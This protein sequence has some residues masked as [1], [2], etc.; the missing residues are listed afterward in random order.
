VRLLGWGIGLSMASSCT[1]QHSSEKVGSTSMP[2]VVIEHT[3][4]CSRGP[5]RYEP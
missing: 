2:R 4:Q 1:G 3:T 5:R